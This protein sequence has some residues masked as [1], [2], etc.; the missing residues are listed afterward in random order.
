MPKRKE[1]WR[2]GWTL[3]LMLMLGRA[4]FLE[5]MLML[6]GF[7][8]RCELFAATAVHVAR[9]AITGR[10]GLDLSSLEEGR[11]VQS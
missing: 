10:R 8:L 1:E 2:E 7:Y 11:K 6:V 3:M 5:K 4:R 9:Q